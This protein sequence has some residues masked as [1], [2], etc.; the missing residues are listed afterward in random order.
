MTDIVRIFAPLLVWLALFSG[1][2]GLHGIGCGLDWPH[3][4]VGP[5]PLHRTALVAAWIGAVILQALL[6]LALARPLRSERPFVQGVSLTL[7]VSGLVAV[8]WTLFPVIFAT[9]CR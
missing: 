2:Y 6:L 8:G 9:S 1:V 4:S 7:A 5:W 3:M